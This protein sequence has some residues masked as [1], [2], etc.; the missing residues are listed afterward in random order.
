MRKGCPL[1]PQLFKIVLEVLHT[2]IREEKEIEG[3]QIGE[4][5]K[6]LCFSVIHEQESALGTP[7]SPASHLPPHPTLP[8]VAEPLLQFPESHSKFPLPICLTYGIVNFHVGLSV[9]LPVPLLPSHCVHRSVLYV[10]FSTAA[11]KV[12]SSV[13]SLQIPYMC[14]SI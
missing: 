9:H 13:P 12:N 4:E 3:I 2:T 14:V 1:L 5:V 8:P 11:L 7:M 10:C 6:F